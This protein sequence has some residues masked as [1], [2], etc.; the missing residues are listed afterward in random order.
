MMSIAS[1]IDT[2]L[3]LGVAVATVELLSLLVTGSCTTGVDSGWVGGVASGWV[4]FAAGSI[5]ISFISAACCHADDDQLLMCCCAA[6]TMEWEVG[7]SD[8][9]ARWS[10]CWASRGSSSSPCAARLSSLCMME[11]VICISAMRGSSAR[12]SSDDPPDCAVTGGGTGGEGATPTV[13]GNTEPVFC[14]FAG[15]SP[16]SVG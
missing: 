9:A 14:L 16:S 1:P 11:S 10:T 8:L 6:Q 13:A 15:G 5:C 3:L 7:C 12:A 4:G 2:A